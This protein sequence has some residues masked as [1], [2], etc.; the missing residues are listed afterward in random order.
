MSFYFDL[1]A[2]GSKKGNFI[3]GNAYDDFVHQV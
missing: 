3:Y 1:H 2:H